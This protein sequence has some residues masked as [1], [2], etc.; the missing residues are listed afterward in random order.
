MMS[1]PAEAP[2][3]IPLWEIYPSAQNA[4]NEKEAFDAAK[5]HKLKRGIVEEIMAEVRA[6]NGRFLK[7]IKNTIYHQVMSGDTLVEGLEE[8]EDDGEDLWVELDDERAIAKACQVMRDIQRPD[9]ANRKSK[10][11]IAQARRS[12]AVRKALRGVT[13]G[14]E[15]ED[16]KSGSQKSELSSTI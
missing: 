6:V 3:P 9:L 12:V 15:G 10:R 2:L 11:Q 13:K 8:Y 4:S 5:H 7:K 16:V 14:D 1:S